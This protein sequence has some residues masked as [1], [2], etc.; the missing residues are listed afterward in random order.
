MTTIKTLVP[1]PLNPKPLNQ[2]CQAVGG[3]QFLSLD[4]SP[5]QL[6]H[7]VAA[8]RDKRPQ[9]AWVEGL[10][11]SGRSRPTNKRCFAGLNGSCFGDFEGLVQGFASDACQA[12]GDY[13][14]V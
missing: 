6:G 2:T 4:G 5:S 11:F 3:V 12:Y 14:G 13:I 10:G 7:A 1:R 9:Q 8:I